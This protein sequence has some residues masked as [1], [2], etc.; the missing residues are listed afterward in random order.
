MKAVKLPHDQRV[1]VN[2]MESLV[3]QEVGKQ[4]KETPPRIRRYLRMEEVVT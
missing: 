4:I 2:V 3:T 1:Y